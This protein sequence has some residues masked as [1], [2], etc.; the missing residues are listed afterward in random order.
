[1]DVLVPDW[2]GWT[3]SKGCEVRPSLPSSARV[4]L[5]FGLMRGMHAGPATAVGVFGPLREDAPEAE[6]AAVD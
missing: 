1:M 2:S 3:T 5:S 6:V 4:G